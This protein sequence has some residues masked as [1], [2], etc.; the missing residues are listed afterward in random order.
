M[1]ATVAFGM[2]IDKPDVRFVCHADMPASVEAYYQEIGRAGRDGLPADTLTLYGFDDMRAA[3]PADRGER[4]RRGAQAHRA[5]APDALLALCEAP[6]CRRQALLAYF[7]EASRALRQLRPLPSS[8]VAR[9]RRHGRGAEGAVGHRPHRR[10]FRHGASDRRAHG[11]EDRERAEVQP[12]PAADLRCRRRPQGRRVALA[13]PPA[14]GGRADRAEP[15][16]AWPLVG[17][18]RRLARAQ[19]RRAHRI[20]QGP[21]RWR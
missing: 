16:G 14:L 12:R 3:P 8:G 1:T 15:A 13:L 18:R 9:Y 5:P 21:G 10:A 4:D 20:A 11:R 17:D 6:R 7:G 2:G 19:G